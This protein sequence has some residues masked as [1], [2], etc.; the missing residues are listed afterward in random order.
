MTWKTKWRLSEDAADCACSCDI[1][2]R[3]FDNDI[4]YLR[5]DTFRKK[6]KMGILAIKNDH[7]MLINKN[8]WGIFFCED[9][10]LP[11]AYSQPTRITRTGKN[12]FWGSCSENES[13]VPVRGQEL[14]PALSHQ[15]DRILL[16]LHT[17]QL[18]TGTCRHVRVWGA[19]A[20]IVS[21][22]KWSEGQVIKYCAC[23]VKVEY[24]GNAAEK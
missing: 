1:L 6:S 8:K 9:S 23:A 7:L 16:H 15:V 10:K 14:F 20:S 3:N 13:C 18:L 22:V 2:L 24:C 4:D 17:S 5:W 12:T 19:C 11:W 21:R